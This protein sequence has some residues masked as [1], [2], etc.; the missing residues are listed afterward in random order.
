MATT[1][2]SMTQMSDL[3]CRAAPCLGGAFLGRLLFVCRAQVDPVTLLDKPGVKIVEA[4]QLIS[5]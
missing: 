1:S 4:S 3:I 2:D 5:Q